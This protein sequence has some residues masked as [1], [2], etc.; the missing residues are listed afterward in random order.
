MT[1]ILQALAKPGRDPREDSPAPLSR[2]KV[3]KLSDLKIGSIVKGTVQN[4]VDFGCFVDIGLKVSGLVHR[5]ELTHKRFRHP[6]DVVSV[7]QIVDAMIISI[8]EKR[9]RIGLSLKQ[10]PQ[11]K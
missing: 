10:V 5:S 7:G 8:D 6:L 9:N 11:E 4:V 3:T 2:K 1:D